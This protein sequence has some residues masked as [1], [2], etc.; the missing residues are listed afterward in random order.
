M[1]SFRAFVKTLAANSKALCSPGGGGQRLTLV[2]GNESADLDS[3]VC[4]LTLAYALS[5]TPDVVAIPVM[6]V[7]RQD[8]KLR[9]ESDFILHH[10]LTTCE[11]TLDALTFIDDIDLNQL[12]DSQ[13]AVWL[14]DHNAP[15]HR[16]AIL[17]P[18]VV[19]IIDHHVDEGK[20]LLAERQIQAV[21]SC[22]TLVAQRFPDK[23]DPVVARLLLAAILVD[24]SNLN[25]AACRA[26]PADI[27]CAQRLSALI[28][29]TPTQGFDV[30]GPGEFYRTLDSLKGAVSHLSSFDLLRKDY[31]Q[32]HVTDLQ[33]KKWAV[34]I[35]SFS[36][37][38]AKWLKRDGRKDI[39]QAVKHWMQTQGLDLVLVMTHGKTKVNGVKTYGR[40]LVVASENRG[41]V[42]KLAECEILGLVPFDGG[43]EP[44]GVYLFMQ[45]RTESS[46]KQVFPAIKGVIEG[47]CG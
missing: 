32:W 1:V 4:S 11:T 34:G 30:N 12:A 25:P 21:G 44:D 38:L 35:S 33:G 39:E 29:W 31:K 2:L 9:P 36:L 20:C 37:P 6:N 45:C 3:L 15:A 42:D 5:Q 13:T 14:V 22:A 18:L 8:M 26:T 27:E 43:C 19:G 24:T 28:D 16:Q 46:R 23:I 10:A 40:Q 47:F 17:E 7:H 41:V